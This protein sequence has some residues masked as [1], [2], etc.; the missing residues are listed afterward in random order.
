MLRDFLRC[1]S[2]ALAAL[3]GLICA[4]PVRI[5]EGRAKLR[6][7]DFTL[8]L[9]AHLLRSCSSSLYGREEPRWGWPAP[10]YL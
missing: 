7:D 10:A 8:F 9:S 6:P 1:E 5:W 3:L 2:L 4:A